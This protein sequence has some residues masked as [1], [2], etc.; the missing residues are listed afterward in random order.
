VSVELKAKVAALVSGGTGG[1]ERAL[2]E[3]TGALRR[4]KCCPNDSKG[5]KLAYT[6]TKPVGQNGN[7]G[8]VLLQSVWSDF[9]G[10]KIR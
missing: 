4:K 7:P 5:G 6:A 3:A 1:V 10:A 9:G 8:L 2:S